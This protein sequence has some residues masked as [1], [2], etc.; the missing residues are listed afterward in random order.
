[1]VACGHSAVRRMRAITT[2]LAP[3]RPLYS[4]AQPAVAANRTAAML[5]RL[6]DDGWL[7]EL[8]SITL[9]HPVAQPLQLGAQPLQLGAIMR[10]FLRDFAL[11]QLSLALMCVDGG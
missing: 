5:E 4:W 9:V 10:A 7:Y 2:P 1:V 11:A 6:P 8:G 3:P